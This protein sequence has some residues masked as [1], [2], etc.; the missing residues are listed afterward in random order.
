[1]DTNYPEHMKLQKVGD[2]SQKIGEFVEWLGSEKRITLVIWDEADQMFIPQYTGI[3]E[4]LAEFFEIDLKKL[5]EEKR[6]MLASAQQ[7]GRL[8]ERDSK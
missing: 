6:A 4:L 7:A 5:E 1:M 3:Q 8:R 2:H